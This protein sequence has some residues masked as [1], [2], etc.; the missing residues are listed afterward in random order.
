[1]EFKIKFRKSGKLFWRTEKVEAYRLNNGRLSLY[2]KDGSI[3][4]IA[5]WSEYD[6]RLGTDWIAATKNAME[7]E[8]AQP[9]S[10]ANNKGN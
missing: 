7:Q 4:E 5:N 3:E 2:F 8:A 6:C 1:M 10:L 9:M